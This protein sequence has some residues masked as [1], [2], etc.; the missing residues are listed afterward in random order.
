MIKFI[1]FCSG[2][3][4]NVLKLCPHEITK[5]ISV[6]ISVLLTSIL[7]S[8]SG[9]YALNSTLNSPIVSL[10]F[11]VIW[12][13]VI[14]NTDRYIVSS[15]LNGS[16]VKKL[17]SILPRLA[18]SVL[19]A[20]TISKPLEIKIFEGSVNEII[21]N[22]HLAK[23]NNLEDRINS[24]KKELF[25]LI[26]ESKEVNGISD[27]IL[28]ELKLKSQSLKVNGGKL[29]R[30][31]KKD[32]TGKYLRLL[33]DNSIKLN[34]VAT[35]MEIRKK[36]I[37]NQIRVSEKQ[38]QERIK[39]IQTQLSKMDKDTIDEPNTDLLAKLSALSELKSMDGTANIASGLI[40]V[41]FILVEMSPI[42]IK[43]MSD[44]TEYEMALKRHKDSIN[45]ASS[46][47]IENDVKK[48][49]YKLIIELKTN[50]TTVDYIEKKKLYLKKIKID[51]WYDSKLSEI[52]KKQ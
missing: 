2:Y 47:I 26:K 30:L 49:K 33:R 50:Q 27:P 11:G 12:G 8:I 32:S 45:E 16:G 51:K 25:A 40:T 17:I 4:E 1:I 18:I 6:G 31:S 42:L 29:T 3:N 22:K 39:G 23:K 28:N 44:N 14:F 41:L 36:E 24:T 37:F 9:G 52:N 35:D 38:S 43:I 7:A 21:N 13:A 48:R 10:L 34:S 20:V 46:D 5:V 19:L 15:A